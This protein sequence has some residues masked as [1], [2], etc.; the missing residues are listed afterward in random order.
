[1]PTFES[2]LRELRQQILTL[3]FDDAIATDQRFNRN[4]RECLYL[5]TATPSCGGSRLDL[6]R[7]LPYNL[8]D[9]LAT[10]HGFIPNISKTAESLCAVYSDVIDDVRHALGKAM[11]DFEEE[12]KVAIK[13]VADDFN[14]MQVYSLRAWRRCHLADAYAQGRREAM[15]IEDHCGPTGLGS[16]SRTFSDQPQATEK[17][18]PDLAD[19][20]NFVLKKSIDALTVAENTA[21]EAAKSMA[22]QW[23]T[24]QSA[25]SEYGACGKE[26]G[27]LYDLDDFEGYKIEGTLT[28]VQAKMRY[29]FS[30]FSHDCGFWWLEGK[31]RLPQEIAYGEKTPVSG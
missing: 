31:W 12:E 11:G 13:Y 30:L 26:K 28:E 3:A 22:S 25:I 7:K 2:L 21:L 16:S 4:I 14:A 27:E 6:Y 29:R 23:L 17:T 5:K 9:S 20:I 19:E 10:G 8:D 18:L 24:F 1:M 15:E